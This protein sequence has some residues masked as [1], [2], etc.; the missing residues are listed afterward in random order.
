MH[1]NPKQAHA[2]LPK[3]DPGRLY[4]GCPV[5]LRDGAVL[6]LIAGGYSAVEIAALQGTNIT[7]AGGYVVITVQRRGFQLSGPLPV[8]LGARVL[9][10]LTERRLWSTSEKVFTG[11]LGPL[12][13]RGVRK[14]LNRYCNRRPTRRLSRRGSR[15][16]R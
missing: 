4:K 14:I 10:W 1:L 13:P 11:V 3:V 9:A 6:A 8:D 2:V 5:G 15:R 16:S 7:M 12:T